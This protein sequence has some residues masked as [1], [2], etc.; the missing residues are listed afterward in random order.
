MAWPSGTK[1]PNE[2]AVEQ[3]LIEIVRILPVRYRC[4]RSTY[5]S[6]RLR[7]D[8][9]LEW[10]LSVSELIEWGE[11]TGYWP[12]ILSPYLIEVH[13][14]QHYYTGRWNERL[15]QIKHSD[16]IKESLA[17]RYGCP[18]LVIPHWDAWDSD[19]LRPRILDFVRSKVPKI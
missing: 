10:S 3:V 8:F 5:F 1:S 18:F 2:W 16:A 17:R 13:G 15:Y 6:N 12:S 11:K 9:I 14:E 7:Y 4:N 19:K